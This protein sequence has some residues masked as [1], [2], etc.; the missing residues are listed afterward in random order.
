MSHIYGLTSTANE[1]GYCKYIDIPNYLLS[2]STKVSTIWLSSVEISKLAIQY[3]LLT[4]EDVVRMGILYN[5]YLNPLSTLKH[6]DF[7]EP[8]T[9]FSA[10]KDLRKI[11]SSQLRFGRCA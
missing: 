7:I 8:N 4:K 6:L 3:S 10:L 1:A 2:A 5:E 11:F 9:P